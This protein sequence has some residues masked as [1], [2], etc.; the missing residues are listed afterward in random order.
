MRK[1]NFVQIS[2][3]FGFNRA[4]SAVIEAAILVS[5]L[6]ILPKD[7]II[8]EMKYLKIAVEK[9]AGPKE[10]EAWLWLT[11]SVNEFISRY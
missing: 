9:T 4:Q 11:D 8:N 2:S 1:K 3:F 6:N 10:K 5:R 7:K